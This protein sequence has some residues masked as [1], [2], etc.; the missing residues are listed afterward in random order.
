MINLNE[1][2]K[3]NIFLQF[4][5]KKIELSYEKI[6]HKKVYNC[7]IIV[8]IPEG[9]TCFL[10]FHT[11]KNQNV[12]YMLEMDEYKKIKNISI[13][14]T[15]FK[16]KLSY[17]TILYGT[18][19]KYKNNNCFTIENIYYYK[20]KKQDIMYFKKLEIIQNMLQNEISL[21]SLCP[22]FVIIGLPLMNFENNFNQILNEIEL[23]PYKIKTIQ[24]HT[25]YNS[26]ENMVYF[27]SNKNNKFKKAIFKVIPDLQ[28]DIYHLYTYD[29][30]QFSF[31]DFA[32]IPDYKTSI[33]M[34][35]LFRNIKE[36]NNL[37]SLEESDSEDE[38]ENPKQDKFVYLDRS[39]YILCQYNLK[40]KKWIP[41]CL[42]NKKE[43]VTSI[44]QIN[45]IF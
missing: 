9:I 10:W 28:N 23:L 1:D 39:Y 27:K 20:G 41:T 25:K 13:I 29:N 38:F 40:F 33:W 44:H 3:N 7:N 24:F 31:F 45:N 35:S 36:N 8:A 12:C 19:F 11:Y 6:I 26:I 15:S 2:E 34:N 17:G 21:F 4:Q 22:N 5:K 32:L 18:F 30:G 14:V 16:D 37:D 42:L 43:K